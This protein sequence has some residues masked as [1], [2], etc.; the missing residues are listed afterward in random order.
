MLK[1]KKSGYGPMK[2]TLIGMVELKNPPILSPIRES[3]YLDQAAATLAV[4]TSAI[5]D[6]NGGFMDRSPSL[7]DSTL[8]LV[9]GT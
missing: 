6:W 1:A 7:V 5:T 3:K 8:G 9:D 4:P 2:P